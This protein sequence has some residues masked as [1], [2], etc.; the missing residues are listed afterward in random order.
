[1]LCN[2]IQQLF[3]T[4]K[5]PTSLNVPTSRVFSECASTFASKEQ[6][7]GVQMSI[8][9]DCIECFQRS[10]AHWT[11][12]GESNRMIC[13]FCLTRV[14]RGP[15]LYWSVCYSWCMTPGEK[16]AAHE[17]TCPEFQSQST[18]KDRSKKISSQ[19][20][21]RAPRVQSG[22]LLL[23]CHSSLYRLYTR[24]RHMSWQQ[25]AARYCSRGGYAHCRRPVQLPKVA[26]FCT[27]F[28]RNLVSYEDRQ[29]EKVQFQI[30]FASR[31]IWDEQDEYLVTALWYTKIWFF[32]IF[33]CICTHS[34]QFCIPKLVV[35]VDIVTEYIMEV[36]VSSS[37]QFLRHKRNW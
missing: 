10:W 31:V 6:T 19:P 29:D 4:T 24:L 9:S 16:S 11:Q 32:W 15:H 1:M 7:H 18:R 13:N 8:T 26:L 2:S 28:V 25:T 35:L 36:S 27:S 12:N 17:C 5:C 22:D 30:E 21:V 3:V 14:F 37:C 23:A 20:R 33:Y 34:R